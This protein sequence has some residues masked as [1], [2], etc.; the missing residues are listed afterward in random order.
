MHSEALIFRT[1]GKM[2]ERK[3]ECATRCEMGLLT[4]AVNCPD[5]SSVFHNLGLGTC[6]SSLLCG[7]WNDGLG[8]R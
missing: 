8:G 4:A 2:Q 7:L 3:G 6:D 1:V 5:A